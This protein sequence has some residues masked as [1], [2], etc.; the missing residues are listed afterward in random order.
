MRA[1]AEFGLGICE[2]ELGNFEGAR[3]IYDEIVNNEAFDGTVNIKQAQLRLDMMADYKA[4]VVFM[5]KPKPKPIPLKPVTA[6]RGFRDPN[7]PIGATLPKVNF[8]PVDVNAPVIIKQ[9]TVEAKEAAKE[10]AAKV[11]PA[12]PDVRIETPAVT[13]KPQDS[14]SAPKAIDPNASSS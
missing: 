8:G 5:P 9:A 2:E 10:A 14:N 13:L 11:V 7:R 12:E 1:A 3:K 6:E 4:S